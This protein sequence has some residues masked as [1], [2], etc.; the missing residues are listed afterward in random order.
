M[1]S[2]G[3]NSMDFLFSAA[4]AVFGMFLRD[5][6]YKGDFTFDKAFELASRKRY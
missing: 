3:K 5:S 1:V 6:P 2:S 4:V